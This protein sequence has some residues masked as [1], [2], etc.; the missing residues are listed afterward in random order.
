MLLIT[1]YLLA[2]VIANLTV[3]AFGPAVSII[4]AFLFIAL[5]L[6]SRDTLHELWSKGNHFKR[7]MFLLIASGSLLSAALNVNAANIAA[8]SFVAFLAS[9][10]ADTVTYNLLHKHHVLVKMNG[11]NVVSAGVDS[12]IFPILAFGWFPALPLIIAG[13]FLAKFFGG[14][15]W[16]WILTRK[17]VIP[18]KVTYKPFDLSSYKCSHCGASGVKLWRD[19]STLRFALLCAPDA[20][21]I[22]AA[23]ISS[24]TDDG[25]IPSPLI[26]DTEMTDQIGWYVPAVPLED[27]PGYWGYTS[28]PIAGVE[29]WKSLP[30]FVTP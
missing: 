13:E 6:T 9:N 29:W 16:S 28:V 3:A 26:G 11:S 2:I 21:H 5:D 24:M 18:A 30:N 22:A 27:Q 8:A 7:N 14:L 15:I 12:V 1:A 20:A 4:N 19:Y 23:V 17:S 10:I 25:K